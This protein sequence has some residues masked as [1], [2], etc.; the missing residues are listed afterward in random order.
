MWHDEN[1]LP[2]VNLFE[3]KAFAYNKSTCTFRA[4][5]L[6]LEYEISKAGEN[7]MLY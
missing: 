7:A 2:I 4:S 5:I 3:R 6:Q 1:T